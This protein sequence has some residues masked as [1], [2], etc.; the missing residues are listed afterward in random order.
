MS[1]VTCHACQ[2]TDIWIGDLTEKHLQTTNIDSVLFT[3]YR[4]DSLDVLKNGEVD[5][6]AFSTPEPE[7]G[8]QM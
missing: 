6:E 1:N 7:M 4:D 2:F 8:C 3:I 5:K